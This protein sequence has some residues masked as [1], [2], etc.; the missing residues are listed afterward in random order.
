MKL[1]ESPSLSLSVRLNSFIF[2]FYIPCC[3][4]VY[5]RAFRI[6][7]AAVLL[8]ETSQSMMAW[9]SV[10]TSS[11]MNALKRELGEKKIN[12]C[13]WFFFPTRKGWC[14]LWSFSRQSNFFS[15]HLEKYC[16]VMTAA[17]ELV[18][19]WCFREVVEIVI[20]YAALT[21]WVAVDD[22]GSLSTAIQELI[23]PLVRLSRT[24]TK[25]GIWKE[26]H[27]F[28]NYTSHRF[29]AVTSAIWS[30][31]FLLLS[32]INLLHG[33]HCLCEVQFNDDCRKM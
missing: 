14:D 19:R 11:R 6:S 22:T 28:S 33:G 30:P 26:D 17:F 9:W 2:Q 13:T 25:K 21:N 32:S 20:N 23:F 24:V 5:I 4:S 10:E 12:K 27:V 31:T 16:A 8:P 29:Q 3:K 15:T 18:Q 1:T 7:V